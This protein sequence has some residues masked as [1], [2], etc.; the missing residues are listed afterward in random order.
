MK[1]TFINTTH[2]EGWV[3]DHK[4][5]LKQS[6]EKSKNPGTEYITGVVNIATDD[7]CLNVVPVHFAY[8]TAITAKNK[9]NAT[10]NALKS[11]IDGAPCVTKDGK[12]AA[13]KLRI[14]SAIGLNEWFQDGKDLVST[15]RNEGGFVHVVDAIDE[16]EANRNTFECDMIINGVRTMEADAEKNLPAKV[17]VKGV[18]F[19]YRKAILPV[20]F[21]VTSAGGMKYFERL[22][23]SPRTPLFTKVWG[24]QLSQTVRTEV[25]EESAFGEDSVRVR[26][27][28]R[29]D[30]VITGTAREK[31]AWDDET[32][33]L[34]S[35]LDEMN[36]AREVYL[37]TKKQQDEEYRASKGNSTAT[38]TGKADDYQF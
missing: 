1:K 24:R 12:D 29:K 3:Y 6:G 25:R 28:S 18:I 15:K 35:D 16:V 27:S 5:E 10:F 17:I 14:D 20:E 26:E 30:F 11:I 4:L 7:A 8:T 32:T 33:I 19:D 31:Y 22:D 13:M 2:I 9:P 23:V 21:S 38:A 36:A 37:A 34:A